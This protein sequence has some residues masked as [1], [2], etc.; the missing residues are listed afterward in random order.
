MEKINYPLLCYELED[1]LLLGI[2]VGTDIEAMAADLSSLKKTLL[3]YLQKQ[4]KKFDE[5][6]PMDIEQPRMK[7]IEVKVRPT[8]RFRSSAYPLPDAIKVR[9]PVVYGQVEQGHYECHLP[10]FR[11]SFYYYDEK[12]FDALVQHTA[13][14]LLNQVNPERL[15]RMLRYPKPS[16]HTLPLKVNYER[17][18]YWDDFEFKQ[19]HELL[20]QLAERFPL[21]RSLR[22]QMSALPEAAWQR[23]QAVSETANKIIT[24]RANVLIVGPNGSGKSAVLR[25]AMKQIHSQ[26]R[27]QQLGYTFWR[28][29]PQRITASSKYLGEWEEK[30]EALIQELSLANGIAWVE[31]IIRLIQSGGEGPEDSLGA[32]MMNFLRQGKLQMIGE[33]TPQE[34]ESMRRLLPGF[35]E[36]FQIVKLKELQEQDI[37]AIL[38]Q[39]AQYSA[40]QLRIEVPEGAQQLIYRLL[41]RYYPYESFPGKAVRFLGQCLNQARYQ[42][43]DTIDQ[44]AVLREFIQQT[45]LPELFLRDEMQLDTKALQ[46]FFN[47]HIIGQPDAV[48][49]MCSVVKIYKAGINNPKKPIVSMLFAGPTGVGKTASAKALS[50][51][52]FGKGKQKSPLIRIDMSEFQHPEQITSLIGAGRQAGKLA[53]GVRERPFS[54]L[55]LDEVEKASPVIFDLLLNL[56]DEG[57]MVDAYGR[58]T[59]FRNTIIV[60]TSNLGASNRPSVGFSDNMPTDA[61]YRSAI[62]RHFRPEFVNRIDELVFFRPLDNSDILRITEKELQE[63]QKR[64]GFTKRG[65]ELEFTPELRQHIAQ[66]GFDERYGARPLQRAIEDYIVMPAAQWMLAHQKVK[67]CRLKVDLDEQR[68]TRFKTQPKV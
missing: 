7:E 65:I 67:N 12:Q 1:N 11:D 18:Y 61:V 3:S 10:H 28:I 5:F 26:S 30:C 25:Q 19:A 36:T 64:E 52:F 57:L 56:L 21:Q 41:K 8:Y 53:Q 38:S 9:L 45:G 27:K 58:E 37:M 46:G 35:A 48:E 16:L 62:E 24:T 6:P 42:S 2:L 29:L 14:N 4:Y 50:A 47:E 15:Y 34:L 51:Y 54:V 60:M 33:A 22:R 23:E 40:Q 20:N 63:L 68:R 17:E 59:N 13:L 55:L 43:A 39:F 44:A 66:I 32:F 31:N 49:K